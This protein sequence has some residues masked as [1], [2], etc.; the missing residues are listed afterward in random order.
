MQTFSIF[1]SSGTD[2]KENVKGFIFHLAVLSWKSVLNRI[3]WCKSKLKIEL[4]VCS[5]D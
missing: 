2:E 4:N 5:V 3:E 1:L